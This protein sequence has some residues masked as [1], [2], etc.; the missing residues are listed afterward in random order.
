MSYRR[1]SYRRSAA[2]RGVAWTDC[3]CGHVWAKGKELVGTSMK[4]DWDRG[5]GNH[6][7]GQ[8]YCV[9]GRKLEATGGFEPPDRGF[10]D[11]RLNHLATSP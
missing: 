11:L 4:K 5:L 2:W 1:M 3:P 9:S 7:E 6:R 8:T 10:A